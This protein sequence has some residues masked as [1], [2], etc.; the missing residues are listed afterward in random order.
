ML[1]LPRSHATSSFKGLWPMR[2]TLTEPTPSSLKDSRT[3]TLMVLNIPTL[4]RYAN[5]YCEEKE[6]KQEEK[7]E[8]LIC[9]Q[10]HEVGH[11]PVHWHMAGDL[12]AVGGYAS[13][14]YLKNSAIHHSFARCFSIHGSHGVY[15]YN[16]VGYDIMGHC[17]FLEDGIETRNTLDH[18][19][20]ALT[21]YG[22][23]LLSDMSRTY[24]QVCFV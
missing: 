2:T 5:L 24:C 12:D 6:N 22:Y 13:P 1:R 10:H 7:G 3:C 17:Y 9:L 21:Q 16:N 11:Y 8:S 4:V 18:N 20:G 14:T 19:L 23:L 15:V